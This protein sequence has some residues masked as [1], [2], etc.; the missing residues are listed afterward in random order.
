M[1]K[2]L[3]QPVADLIQASGL[4]EQD[5]LALA[6]FFA[7]VDDDLMD[8]F[9]HH[10][11]KEPTWVTAVSQNLRAKNALIQFTSHLTPR[12]L[13]KKEQDFFAYLQI[14]PAT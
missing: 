6:R 11:Q 4:P 9:V 13:W 1:K 8:W 10:A 7:R 2:E 5:Q 3:I 12:D 14:T